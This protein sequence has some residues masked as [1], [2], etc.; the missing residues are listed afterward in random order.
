MRGEFWHVIVMREVLDEFCDQHDLSVRD[1]TAI[2]AAELLMR[3]AAEG[4]VT[5]QDLRDRLNEVMG[6]RLLDDRAISNQQAIAR[7]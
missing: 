2:Q 5:P 7:L 1:H 4:D 3:F 6:D